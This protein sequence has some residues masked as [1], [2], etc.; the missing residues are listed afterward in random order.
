MIPAFSPA[1]VARSEPRY[2]AWSTPIGVMT[3]TVR[4]DDVGG[5]PAAAEADL[6]DADV[7]RGVGERRERHGGDHLELAHRRASVRLGLLIHQL[8]EGFDLAVGVDVNAPG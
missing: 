8:D 7:D 5:V 3:A 1:M 2:S 4:V 6:D